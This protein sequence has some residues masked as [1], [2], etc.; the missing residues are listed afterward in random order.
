[1][2][3]FNAVAPHNGHG[4]FWTFCPYCLYVY[5]Y[6]RLYEGCCLR[7]QNVGCARVFHGVAL[8]SLPKMELDKGRYFGCF[9]Y[10]PMG[11]SPA[12]QGADRMA[13]FENWSPIVTMFPANR[14]EIN[15]NADANGDGDGDGT[16][17]IE[18]LDDSDESDAGVKGEDNVPTAGS[19]RMRRKSVA[20]R[21]R[22]H[23][24]GDASAGERLLS[25]EGG[26][27]V[28]EFEG[29]GDVGDLNE[30]D[31]AFFEGDGEVFVGLGSDDAATL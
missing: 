19:R 24:A 4:G 5:E 3:C 22:R 29:R 15:L 14:N 10:F 8:T 2:E 16:D 18:I 6:D 21:K 17:F 31:M 1:M 9:G 20:R 12:E 7:C 13:K 26:D 28:R 27:Y 25:D 30:V 11:F 23:N